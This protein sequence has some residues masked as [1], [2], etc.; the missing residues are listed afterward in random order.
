MKKICNKDDSRKQPNT[1]KKLNNFH[2]KSRKFL[3][4]PAALGTGVGFV[5]GVVEHVFVVRLLKGE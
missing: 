2:L 5:V 3:E 1:I 4:S